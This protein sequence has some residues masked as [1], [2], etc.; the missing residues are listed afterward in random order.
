MRLYGTQWHGGLVLAVA[1]VAVAASCDVDPP[2]DDGRVGVVQGQQDAQGHVIAELSLAEAVGRGQPVPMVL[3]VMNTGPDT[4]HLGLT[5]RPVAFDI[6]VAAPDGTEVWS[7]LH[8]ATVPMILQ[9][10]LLAPGDTLEYTHTWDQRDNSGRTVEP[11]LYHVQG[12]IPTEDDELRSDP[13]EIRIA[14]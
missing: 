8:G 3:R 4:A 12:V 6:T 14:P 5:G 11:G 13:R 9:M 2:A 1:V 10:A 7:R